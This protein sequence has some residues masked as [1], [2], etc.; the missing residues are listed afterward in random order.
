MKSRLEGLPHETLVGVFF[1]CVSKK[2]AKKPFDVSGSLARGGRFNP[3]NEFAALYLSDSEETCR[4]EVGRR[5]PLA[6]DSDYP[7]FP[8]QIEIYGVLDL[9]NDKS[10]KKLFLRHDDDLVKN[11]YLNTQALAKAARSAGYKAILTLSATGKGKNL[12]IFT[13]MLDATDKVM[14]IGPL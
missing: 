11:D 13:D 6:K 14:P 3:P 7:V 12:I 1:R 2:H 8:A 5:N 4:N 10:R 9:T